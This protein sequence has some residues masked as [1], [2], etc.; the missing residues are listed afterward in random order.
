MN[1]KELEAKLIEI[2]QKL[3]ALGE[4]STLIQSGTQL[5]ALVNQAQSTSTAAQEL[6]P[7]LTT[8]QQTLE[9]LTKEILGLKNE[10]STRNEEIGGLV[11]KTNALQEKT[12]GLRQETLAQLG[13]AASEKLSNSFEQ[14]KI[15]LAKEKTSWF[16]WLVGGVAALVVATATIAVWQV[17]DVG[18]LYHISFFIKI[19]LTSPL[20]YFIIFANREYNRARS[21]I[22]EYTFKA[23]IAR[24]FEAYKEILQDAF[25]DQQP[26]IFQKKLDFMLDA[27][28]G[29][30]SSPMR[31]VKMNAIKEK[32]I[33]PDIVS[34]LKEKMFPEADK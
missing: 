21:L 33:S 26:L 12:D 1:K 15:D 20:V 24:S 2:Q 16:Y 13:L 8:Q 6:L 28:S 4:L 14:V 34:Q 23:A 17:R 32:E 29:L 3:S 31:N 11:E 9:A 10:L 25:A 5:P 27:V 7:K 22:E 30:Y 18:T 19:A